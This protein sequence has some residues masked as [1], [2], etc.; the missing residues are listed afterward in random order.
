MKVRLIL[1]FVCVVSII[2]VM[3]QNKSEHYFLFPDYKEALIYYKDGR[4]FTAPV[5]FDLQAGHFLFIDAKDKKAKQ[6]A[7][8]EKIAFMQIE[9]RNFL[10]SE[11]EAVEILQATPLFQVAYSGNLRQA[12]KNLTY[13]GTTQTAA[14]DSYGGYSGN[15]NLISQQHSKSRVVMG[16]NKNYKAKFRKKNKQFNNSKTFIKAFPKETRS[17]VAEY[18]QANH[19]DFDNV[20]QVFK[21]YERFIPLW[22]IDDK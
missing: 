12:P 15:A 18:I 1:L 16:V 11:N 14:V 2:P 8:P 9:G 22:N 5:N 3:S 4:Q 17:I 6:F 21:L 7:Y 13:G 19:V 10:L 20:N